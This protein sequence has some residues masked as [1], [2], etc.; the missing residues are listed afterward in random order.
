MNTFSVTMKQN[1]VGTVATITFWLGSIPIIT[2][3][4][5]A[6]PAAIIQALFR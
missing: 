4:L 3:L 6:D 5:G 1:M 2:A